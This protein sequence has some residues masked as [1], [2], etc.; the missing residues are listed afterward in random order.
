MTNLNGMTDAVACTKCGNAFSYGTEMF[1]I[2]SG[3]EME[4]YF[5]QRCFDGI[6]KDLNKREVS[7]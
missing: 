2:K 3:S 1:I 5:C 4:V 7:N 6:P